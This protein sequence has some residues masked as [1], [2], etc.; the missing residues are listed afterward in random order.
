MNDYPYNEYN[1]EFVA[2]TSPNPIYF[3][4]VNKNLASTQIT[5]YCYFQSIGHEDAQEF[6]PNCDEKEEGNDR[7]RR[8]TQEKLGLLLSLMMEVFMHM[9]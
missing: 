6:N 9:G 1:S 7:K 3:D 5:Q 8:N 4:C 2:C